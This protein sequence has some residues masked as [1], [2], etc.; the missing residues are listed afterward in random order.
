MLWD[1]GENQGYA[2]HLT[3]DPYAGTQPK[4]VMLL[5][6]FGDHQVANVATE[7]LA[8]TIGARLRAPAL[9]EGRSLDVEP[10]FGIDPVDSY[11]AGGSVLV[12]WDFGTPPPPTSNVPPREG[13]DPHGKA[14]EVPAVLVMV[15]EFL[16]TDGKLV[17]VC[18]GAPCRTLDG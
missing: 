15:S 6:A 14:G 4:D 12:V 18:G 10:F 7:N 11:P 1:R 17:D 2:Q 16:K 8:R 9:E 3:T 5:E 13:E